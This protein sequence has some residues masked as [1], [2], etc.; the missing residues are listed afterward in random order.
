M[1]KQILGVVHIKHWLILDL[2]ILTTCSPTVNILYS[3]TLHLLRGS[4][5][6]LQKMVPQMNLTTIH[7]CRLY[8]VELL[9]SHDHKEGILKD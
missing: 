5:D 8:I 7:V 6:N 2:N 1:D 3:H 4:K 9:S